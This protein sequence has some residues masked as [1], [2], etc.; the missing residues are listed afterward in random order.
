[1]KATFIGNPHDERDNATSLKMFDVLFPLNVAVDLPETL[2]PAQIKK[3]AGNN[4]FVVD[5]YEP[6]TVPSDPSKPAVGTDAS[7]ENVTAAAVSTIARAKPRRAKVE[8]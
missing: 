1:M 4:H 2:T 7:A 6:E 3:L 8:G 5:G